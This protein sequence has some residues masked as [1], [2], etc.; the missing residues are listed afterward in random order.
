M[1]EFNWSFQSS[2]TA[3]ANIVRG[4]KRRPGA[5]SPV[6]RR[7][8]DEQKLICLW[9]GRKCFH[10]GNYQGSAH[11]TSCLEYPHEGRWWLYYMAFEDKWKTTPLFSFKVLKRKL[12][13]TLIFAHAAKQ[14]F[15]SVN[16]NSK[17]SSKNESIHIH[18]RCVQSLLTENKL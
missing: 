16:P 14:H 4:G 10:L 7:L 15:G 9:Q 13:H 12:G 17:W 2:R 18:T 6:R 1:E 8:P 11:R 5:L 3:V